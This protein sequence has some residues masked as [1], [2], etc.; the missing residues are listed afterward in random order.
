VTVQHAPVATTASILSLPIATQ[1]VVIKTGIFPWDRQMAQ[2]AN[3]ILSFPELVPS[4][5][6]RFL[7]WL[8]LTRYVITV[9][10]TSHIFQAQATATAMVGDS[11]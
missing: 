11:T 3:T 4:I 1:V 5:D 2:Q 8:T 9:F 10:I 6:N 7:P